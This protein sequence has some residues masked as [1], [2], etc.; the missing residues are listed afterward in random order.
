MATTVILEVTVV[1][2]I[3]TVEAVEEA[4][5]EAEEGVVALIETEDVIVHIDY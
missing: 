1:V 3:H 2:A 5:E 4:H